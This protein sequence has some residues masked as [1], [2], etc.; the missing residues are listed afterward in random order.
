MTLCGTPEY[1]APEILTNGKSGY[2]SSVDWWSLGILFYEMVVGYPP[3]QDHNPFGIYKKI[4][5]GEFKTHTFLSEE[6]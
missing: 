3:F 2:G 1:L 6:A 5:K 4:I